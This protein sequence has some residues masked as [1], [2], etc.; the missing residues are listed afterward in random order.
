MTL[1]GTLAAVGLCFIIKYGS[2]LNFIR[3]PLTKIPFFKELLSCTL[4]I[5]FHIGFW[6]AI[7]SGLTSVLAVL[8]LACFCSAVCWCFDHF[9][10]VCQKYLYGD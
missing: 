2:I 3:T 10:M 4:C 1:F 9:I 6:T 7:L 8:Q 5:G